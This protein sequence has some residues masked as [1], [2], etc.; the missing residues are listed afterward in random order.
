MNKNLMNQ[1]EKIVVDRCN[2]DDEE[3][4]KNPEYVKQA[5]ERSQKRKQCMKEMKALL[6]Q[7]LAQH[8][9][10][11][12]Y[13][14][15]S[16]DFIDSD[17]DEPDVERYITVKANQQ[18]KAQAQ[19]VLDEWFNLK[20]EYTFSDISKERKVKFAERLEKFIKENKIDLF[21][22]ERGD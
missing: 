8:K 15:T 21:K 19:K 11:K 20:H 3:E 7:Y 18:K 6:H 17:F 4:V 9:I 14:N 22:N 10:P 16:R 2:V 12:N 13:W 5:K 1:I